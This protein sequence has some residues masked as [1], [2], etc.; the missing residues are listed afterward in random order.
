[1][2]AI[3]TS[4]ARCLYCSRGREH[5]ILSSPVTYAPGP[6][7][8]RKDRPAFP[9]LRS[10]WLVQFTIGITLGIPLHMAGL[11]VIGTQEPELRQGNEAS[12]ID[13]A[14]HL[15]Q[16]GRVQEALSLLAQANLR[17]SNT[18]EVHTLKGICF[19]LLAKPIE[20]AEEFDRAIALRPKSASTY[21]SS[22]LAAASFNNLDRALSQLA[23]AVRLDPS[24]PGAR[25]N[26]ALVLAR[27]GKYDESEKQV[28]LE[29]ASKDAKILSSV[30]VWKL[31]ARDT[32]YQKKW[33]DA[34]DAYNKVLAFQPTAPEA[35][36]A[37]GQSLF[38]LNRMAESKAALQKAL[39]LDPA[40]GAAHATL[41]KIYQDGG[42][43]DQAIAEFEAAIR[44]RPDDRD[45]MYRVFRIYS[46]KGDTIN[47][48]RLQNQIKDLVKSN[49]N[50]SMDE[51]KASALNSSAIELEMKGDFNG[52]LEDYDSAAKANST[53]IIFQRNA[54]LLLCKMGRVQEAIRRLRDILAV[55]GNDAETLQILAVAEELGS[56]GGAKQKSLPA[57]QP[58]H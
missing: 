18:A 49:V 20:S 45:A 57:P 19:A 30:D 40:D 38:A 56:S 7:V 36:A 17:D 37:I 48:A 3:C 47:A 33:Q 8:L 58:S 5:R 23:T 46:K 39:R 22:G 31:K 42:Q 1:M 41:G 27:A 14:R 54:A 52:A 6:S 12:Q 11:P 16:A 15:I 13:R 21:L 4:L 25:Y 2:R 50:A 24:L 32:Y 28:D 26:Y 43:D 35:Y 55:D 53:N 51:A 9:G 10:I 29:L 44:E 34:V